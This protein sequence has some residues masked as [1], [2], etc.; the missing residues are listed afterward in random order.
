[1]KVRNCGKYRTYFLSPTTVNSGYC[2]GKE[3]TIFVCPYCVN[4]YLRIKICVFYK[5]YLKRY[6]YIWAVK[7]E[8]EGKFKSEISFSNSR[9][10]K[11][12][13]MK[14]NCYISDLVQACSY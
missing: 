10:Q 14:N 7:S 3:T 13:R 8:L 5:D 6:M 1:M 11:N 9:N 12:K 4:Y 2:F